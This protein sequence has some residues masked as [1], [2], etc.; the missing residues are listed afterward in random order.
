P[1][2]PGRR[3][4]RFSGLHAAAHD[5]ADVQQRRGRPCRRGDRPADDRKQCRAYRWT[6][7]F[8][9]SGFIS[10]LTGSVLG[11]RAA[12][13]NGRPHEQYGNRQD[14]V[15]LLDV[16][17]LLIRRSLPR[18][19][20]EFATIYWAD[21]ASGHD[22]LGSAS[23]L[24]HH[25]ARDDELLDLSGAFINAKQPDVAVEAL[26]AVIA[27][28]PGATENLHRTIGDA[29]AHLG[30][31]QFRAGRLSAHTQSV[32]SPAR[33]VQH[34]AARRIDFRLAVG[35][36]GLDEL[37]FGDGLAELLPLGGIA[38]RVGQ[39]ALGDSDTDGRD[40]DAALIQYL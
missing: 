32:V 30:C 29:A 38:Q 16:R 8:W 35:Q 14:R 28:V 19:R 7:T 22:R 13:G 31:E 34:H 4:W 27:D 10:G 12:D 25:V 37:K 23:Q 21:G 15:A 6:G 26:D 3:V 17:R 40:V 36:H 11:Q 24:A 39:H 33:R 20:L 5:D 2:D 9:R 1:V 18:Q